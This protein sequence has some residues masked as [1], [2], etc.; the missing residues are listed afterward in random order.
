MTNDWNVNNNDVKY[1]HP[2]EDGYDECSSRIDDSSD[3]FNS[4]CDEIDMDLL[5]SMQ[6]ALHDF[7]FDEADVELLLMD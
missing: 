1:N 3:D 4:N 5:N 7:I 6:D 2:L